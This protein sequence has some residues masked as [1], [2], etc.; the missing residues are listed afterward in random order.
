MEFGLSPLSEN[1]FL[2]DGERGGCCLRSIGDGSF[3]DARGE[4]E[5][6]TIFGEGVPRLGSIGSGFDGGRDCETFFNDCL[7]SFFLKSFK[8]RSLPNF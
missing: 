7:V 4:M 3:G 2:G 8:R 1:V 5:L 6:L